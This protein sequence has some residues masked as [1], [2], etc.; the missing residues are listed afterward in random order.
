MSDANV[1][2]SFTASVGDLVSGVADARDALASLS[3]PF[4]QLNGQ[5]ASLGASIGH[6]FD[7]SRLKS[8]RFRALCLGF[9]G[10]LARRRPYASRGGDPFGRR[11]RLLRRD[12]RGE[13]GDRR[14]DQGG[15]GRPQ[16]KA[17]ALRRRGAR[18]SD[19]EQQKVSLSRSALDEEYAARTRA[20][21]AGGR[22]RG[23]EARAGAAGARSNT[24]RRAA[25]SG[26]DEPDHAT[27]A[28]RAAA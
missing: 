12:A 11:R 16:T 3:A 1:A 24:R 6:A 22:A 8:Y 27:G 21:A 2:V 5:Y 7:P 14:G 25:A 20:A 26:P 13:G 4:E 18:T 28:R 9:A 17:R 10:S 23:T 19:H 15:R